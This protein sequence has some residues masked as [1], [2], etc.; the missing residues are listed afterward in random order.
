MSGRDPADA[1]AQSLLLRRLLD[2]AG[3]KSAHLATQLHPAWLEAAWPED[4]PV[5][6]SSAWGERATRR[7]SLLLAQVYGVRWPGLVSLRARAHRIVLLAREP[8]LRVLAAAALYGRSGDVR[9]CVGRQ[10]RDALIALVGEPAYA[11]LLQA[12]DAGAAVR[13]IE[14]ADLRPE[15]CAAQGYQLLLACGQWHCRDASLIARLTLPP[16]A[17][18]EAAAQRDTAPSPLQW[19]GLFGRFDAFFPEQAWMFGSDMDRALSA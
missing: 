10:A 3:H 11:A 13:P 15:A 12:P 18:R 6:P 9:R 5:A 4:W 16:G 8:L 19:S 7:T 17:G 1:S 14:A 2:A